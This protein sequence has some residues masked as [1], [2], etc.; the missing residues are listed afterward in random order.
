[1]SPAVLRQ[2]RISLAG[3]RSQALGVG[4]DRLSY[5]MMGFLVLSAV[6]TGRLAELALL[7][8]D[9]QT[10]T[11]A[12]STR[13]PLRLDITDRNGVVMA[14]SLKVYSFAVNPRM[15]TNARP[16]A[17][18]ISKILP[19]LNE[20]KIYRDL[21]RSNKFVWIKRKIT[22]RQVTLLNALGE[23]GLQFITEYE[24]VYPNG[25]MAA[26]ALGYTNVDGEGIAGV[27]NFFDENLARHGTAATP[28]LVL[29]ID[30]RVQHALEDEIRSGMEKF[31][32]IGGFGVVMDV[33]S[34]A[35][36]AMAS[37]PGFD[38]NVPNLGDPLARFSHVTKGVYE[39]G[40]TFKAFAV[41]QSLDMGT[42]TPGKRF[43][44]TA[45]LKIAGYKIDDFHAKRGWMTT[46]DVF[47][48]SSNIGTARMIDEVGGTNQRAFLDKLGM[49]QAPSIEV[50]E[51]GKPILPE[52]WG[53]LATMTVAYGH[54]MAVTPLQLASGMSA[55]V[56]GGYKISPHLVAQAGETA[57]RVRVISQATSD[58]MRALFRLAVVHGT[59]GY[60]D[61]EG[62]RVG[63]KTGTAEKPVAGGY[64]RSARISTFAA[65]FPMDAPRYVIIM[66][67]DEPK[68]IAA[69]GGYATAGMVAAPLVHNLILRAAPVLGV[70]KSDADVDY[71]AFMPYI[72]HP[73]KK[74]S[75]L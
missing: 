10:S 33:N 7:H 25:F 59:G 62:Y 46:T 18:K 54:G 19:M 1:M 47:I 3:Q 15:I 66:S 43:D 2:L 31:S 29:T 60:S 63:G 50:P 41:A 56:N 32:A 39:L 68:G 65:A 51:V 21:T 11:A 12:L 22:P 61:V 48:H 5:F 57:P 23:P 16:L 71:S 34:G 55:L 17:E 4:R 28:A 67:L 70:A 40:S 9:A 6:L 64:S 58:Q 8:S 37:Q 69:T 30:S 20:A 53:R 75:S 45:P 72:A 35:V 38:P 36:V 24:R 13:R 73:K 74:K 42:T 49:L 26:H 27:E 44:C 52:P 14:T